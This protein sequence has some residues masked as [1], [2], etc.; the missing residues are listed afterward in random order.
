MYCLS[1]TVLLTQTC[2]IGLWANWTAL[3]LYSLTVYILYCGMDTSSDYGVSARKR[4]IPMWAAWTELSNGTVIEFST[5]L[6]F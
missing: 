1:L 6:I 2:G 5:Y 4:V 3:S